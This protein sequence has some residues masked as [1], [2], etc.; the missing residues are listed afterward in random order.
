MVASAFAGPVPICSI[1]GKFLFES[2]CLGRSGIRTVREGRDGVS[3]HRGRKSA[4]KAHASR[5]T[6]WRKPFNLKELN[7]SCPEFGNVLRFV[8]FSGCEHKLNKPRVTP[9][10][11]RTPVGRSSNWQDSRF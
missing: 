4:G 11:S 1:C 6:E 3:N 8:F 7:R 10:F 2:N 9:R 5:L